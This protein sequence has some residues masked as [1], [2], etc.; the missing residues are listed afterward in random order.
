M[1]PAPS[2]NAFNAFSTTDYRP[3][4]PTAFIPLPKEYLST[5]TVQ[6]RLNDKKI[7]V[8]DPSLDKEN[9]CDQ[10]CLAT[11][12]LIVFYLSLVGGLTAFIVVTN[13]AGTLDHSND[14]DRGFERCWL[15]KDFH[16]QND[17]MDTIDHSGDIWNPDIIHEGL[18]SMLPVTFVPSTLCILVYKIGFLWSNWVAKSRLA[19]IIEK[20][21]KLEETNMWLTCSSSID[22]NTPLH[23]SFI[24]N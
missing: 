22:Q 5:E 6:N 21:K 7:V 13:K 18:K 11:V 16:N 10:K 1:D 15:N 23:D 8:V 17:R 14:F 19:P 3:L 9:Y 20:N 2:I 4:N 24:L 12:L